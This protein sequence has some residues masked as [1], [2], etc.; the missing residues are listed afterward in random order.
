[1]VPE[2]PEMDPRPVRTMSDMGM[3]MK[4]MDGIG[5]MSMTGMN[6]P[7][8]EMP[9]DHTQMSAMAV[10]SDSKMKRAIEPQATRPTLTYQFPLPQPGPDTQSIGSSDGVQIGSPIHISSPIKTGPEVATVA[11][12]TVT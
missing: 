9:Q 3:K 4:G 7:G 6:M 10:Q 5:K 2:T 8:M 12:V 1:M 11:A